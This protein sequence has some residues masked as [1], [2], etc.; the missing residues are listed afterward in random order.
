MAGRSAP[1]REPDTTGI[2]ALRLRASG[3][4]EKALLGTRH[5][6]GNFPDILF[7]FLHGG[8]IW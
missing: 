5:F 7:R 1:P 6:K 4:V 2:F 8:V 3:T